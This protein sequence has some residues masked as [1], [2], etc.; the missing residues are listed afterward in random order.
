[1]KNEVALYDKKYPANWVVMQNRMLQVFYEMTLD[2][3]RILILASPI[4]R[5]VDATQDT[6]IEVTAKDFAD[7][8]NIETASAYSQ[9][10][11]ASETIMSRVFNYKNERGKRVNVQW[12]IRSVYE[13]GY[14]SLWFTKEVLVMLKV[15]DEHNP[16]TKY[17][18]NEVLKLRG[19]Y[20]ID[21]YH[22]SKKYEKMTSWIMPLDEIREDF[23][24]SKSYSRINNLKSRVIDPAIKEISEKTDIIVTY[25]NVKRGRT[26]T[27]LKF[28]VR[29]KPASKIKDAEIEKRDQNTADLFTIDN[30]TDKQIEAIVCTEAFKAD[31]NHLI[32]PTSPA[33]TDYRQWKPEMSKRLKS[34]PE[35]FNKRP[36]KYYL[37]RIGDYKNKE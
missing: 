10:Q 32:S 17:K 6:A 35:L 24:L 9:M 2:E 26:V 7:A 11:D 12:V 28:T 15:F 27:G 31:Y 4:A 1:M 22:L 30:L 8:C 23:S 33:N 5:L 18:K 36:M 29:A 21:L 13:D 3:K 20:S 37:D 34:T 14:I 16:F 25:E 19:E